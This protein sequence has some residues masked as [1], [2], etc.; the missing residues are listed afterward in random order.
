METHKLPTMD[1]P[2]IPSAFTMSDE[3]KEKILSMAVKFPQAFMIRPKGS[4]PNGTFAK[5]NFDSSV[6]L[7]IDTSHNEAIEFYKQK[8][9]EE[10]EKTMSTALTT[11][12]QDNVKTLLA[13]NIKAI[14]SVLPNHLTPEKMLRMA[15]T[16]VVINPKLARCSQIS[17]LNAVIEAS[18]IGLEI[19]G[20]LA[21]AHLVPFKEEAKLMVDY[22]GLMELCYR[23]PAVAAMTA[24]PVYQR[25][26]FDYWYGINADLRHVPFKNGDRGD[27]IAAYSIVK[28]TSGGVDFEVVEREDA[29]AAKESSPAK[30]K[31]DSPWNKPRDEWTMW[32]KTAV[33][34]LSKRIPKNP[35]LQKALNLEANPSEGQGLNHVIEADFKTVADPPKEPQEPEKK[36][37]NSGENKTKF[38]TEEQKIINNF[39]VAK[40]SF[41]QEYEEAVKELGFT[42]KT[43]S[44][45]D[46]EKIMKEISNILDQE[47]V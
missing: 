6:D 9:S 23:S 35:E 21:Q 4:S 15:Y 31:K 40:D 33:R 42:G 30:D 32:V 1:G 24:R 29:M 2:W 45:Q 16:S 27:L 46:M 18:A 17:L 7:F 47:A 14:Q 37:D 22:K 10:K 3:F 39:E 5:Y 43:L 38:S 36:T 25:D 12:E 20:P 11:M 41:P 44:I 34:K 19:G 28:F 8:F 13:N 26:Q